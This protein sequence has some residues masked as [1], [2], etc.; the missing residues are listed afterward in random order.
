VHLVT[1]TWHEHLRGSLVLFR[2]DF[3]TVYQGFDGSI[4]FIDKNSKKHL[5]K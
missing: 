5:E 3:E 2:S 1:K 4:F